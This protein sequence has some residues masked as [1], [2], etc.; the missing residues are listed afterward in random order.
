M[1]GVIEG[2]SFP[3]EKLTRFGYITLT[4]MEDNALC[5]KGDEL[6]GHEFHY[7]DS[8]NTGTGFHAQKPLRKTNWDCIITKGNLWAG[9]PH[10]HFYSNIEAAAEYIR[11][12]RGRKNDE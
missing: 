5:G 12:V 7:W 11:K 8:T 1:A 6:R 4:A 3:T 2:E 9:Y 10:I